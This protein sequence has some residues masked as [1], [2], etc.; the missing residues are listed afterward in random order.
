MRRV[1]QAVIITQMLYGA[2]AWYQ[3]SMPAKERIQIA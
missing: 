1:Y 2:A 3:A